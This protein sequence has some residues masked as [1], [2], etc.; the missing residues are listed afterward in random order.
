MNPRNEGI[1]DYLFAIGIFFLRH[2][3]VIGKFSEANNPH[4]FPMQLTPD[5]FDSQGTEEFGQS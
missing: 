1:Q 4:H 5:N 2:F 3:A